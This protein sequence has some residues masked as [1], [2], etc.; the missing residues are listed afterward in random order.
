[1]DFDAVFGGMKCGP[2]LV[3]IWTAGWIKEYFFQTSL[4]G[5]AVPVDSQE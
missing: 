4:F 2:I 3:A 5:V 1:M